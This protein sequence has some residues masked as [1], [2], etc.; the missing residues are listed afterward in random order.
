MIRVAEIATS[1]AEALDAEDYIAA[2][3]LLSEQCEYDCRDQFFVGPEDIIASYRANGD[4]AGR[5]FDCVEYESSVLELS[6]NTALIRFKDHVLHE[7]R[8]F[9]FECEQVIEVNH[10]GRICVIAH[11]DLPGQREALRLF[12]ESVGLPNS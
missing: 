1:F 3:E 11:R 4:S 9:T 5:T 6:E 12:K 2:Q 10:A 8:R 7:G